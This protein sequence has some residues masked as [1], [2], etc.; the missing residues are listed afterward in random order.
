MGVYLLLQE[1]DNIIFGT[2][3]LLAMPIYPNYAYANMNNDDKELETSSVPQLTPEQIEQCEFF[4]KGLLSLTPTEYSI[5][6][7]YVAGKN[8]NEVMKILGIQTNTIKFHN[9][10]LYR[11]LGVSS[12]KQMI[13]IDSLIKA[14]ESV[15]KTV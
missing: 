3:R 13:E 10:N 15:E 14:V 6:E 11:K 2:T 7:Y 1:K 5:Y 8:A 4:T 12:R 9:K